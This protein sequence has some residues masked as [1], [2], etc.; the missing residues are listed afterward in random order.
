MRQGEASES[1]LGF[2][3]LVCDSG[4][5]LEAGRL[6]VSDRLRDQGVSRLLL[7]AHVCDVAGHEGH[8]ILLF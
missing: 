1:C 7:L 4:V 3:H 6:L 2:S 5:L 8:L